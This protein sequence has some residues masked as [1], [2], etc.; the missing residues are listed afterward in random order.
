MIELRN[1]IISVIYRM[2]LGGYGYAAKSGNHESTG[3]ISN[4]SPV[5]DDFPMLCETCLGTNPFLR[6]VF[7]SIY[8]YI[9][10][11]KLIYKIK[12]R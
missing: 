4:S 8:K 1:I 6:M 3:G 10:F 11:I 12:Y 5:G 7:N 2:N 9:I